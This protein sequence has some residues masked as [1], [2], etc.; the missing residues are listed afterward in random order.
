MFKPAAEEVGASWAGFH[1]LRHTCASRL[2]KAGRNPVQV[3][4]WLGHHSPAFTLSTYAHLMDED[5]GEPLPLPVA[6]VSAGVSATDGYSP[7]RPVA[8]LAE[9]A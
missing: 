3:Q 1:T 2:F 6:G 7:D 8:G 5:L 9:V 4:R